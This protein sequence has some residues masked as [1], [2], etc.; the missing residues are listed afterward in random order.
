MGCRKINQTG[1]SLCS[2]SKRKD[3]PPGVG[4]WPLGCYFGHSI[5]KHLLIMASSRLTRGSSKVIAGV[6]SGI[7]KHFGWDPVLIRVLFLVAFLGF[8]TG[9]LLY[10]I[11]WIVMPKS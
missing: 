8:G 2:V 5:L 10:L 11:L 6:C 7:A 1:N 9:L 4:T 3:Y